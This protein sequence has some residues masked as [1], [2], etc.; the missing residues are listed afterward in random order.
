MFVCRVEIQVIGTRSV[1]DM[2]PM[3]MSCATRIYQAQQ[4]ALHPCSGMVFATQVHFAHDG[5]VQHF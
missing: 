3:S 5:N 1:P 2:T 4:M